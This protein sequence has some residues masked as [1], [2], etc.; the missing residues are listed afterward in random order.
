MKNKIWELCSLSAGR[1]AVSCKWV[2]KY[3]FNVQGEIVR[4]KS[5]FVVRGFF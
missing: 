3:K 4:Y 5:R 2:F 1:K